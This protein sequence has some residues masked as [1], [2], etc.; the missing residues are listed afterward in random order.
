VP[1]H[2]DAPVA[3]SPQELAALADQIEKAAWAPDQ[4]AWATLAGIDNTLVGLGLVPG[5]GER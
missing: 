3:S 1:A 5:E 2:H 4:G